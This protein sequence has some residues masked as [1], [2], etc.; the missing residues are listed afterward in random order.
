MAKVHVS[1]RLNGP[2]SEVWGLIGRW[3]A[4]PDWHPAVL[5]SELSEDGK[6]RRLTLSGGGLLVVVVVAD[7]SPGLVDQVEPAVDTGRAGSTVVVDDQRPER[8]LD[9]PDGT[10]MR[11]PVG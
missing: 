6:V 10:R 2:A 5:K 4:L 8:G 1:A 11:E 3:N 9:A 7:P